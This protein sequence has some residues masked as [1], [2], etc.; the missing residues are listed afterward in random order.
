MVE[1]SEHKARKNTL[2]SPVPSR[3]RVFVYLSERFFYNR[4]ASAKL[5]ACLAVLWFPNK[6]W[7]LKKKKQFSS[8]VGS[9][10]FFLPPSVSFSLFS[11]RALLPLM[12]LLSARL[13]TFLFLPLIFLPPLSERHLLSCCRRCDESAAVL[14]HHEMILSPNRDT[15]TNRYLGKH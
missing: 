15:V 8:A 6:F 14:R 11:P 10:L 3:S 12:S 2:A 9:L 13:V 5:P 7:W 1:D 4:S